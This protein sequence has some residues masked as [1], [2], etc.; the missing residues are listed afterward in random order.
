LF[1][2]D[3]AAQT[4]AHF[5]LDKESFKGGYYYSI[6]EL[7]G[8]LNCKTKYLLHL[9]GDAMADENGKWIEDTIIYMEKDR[10]I[11]VSATNGRS[12]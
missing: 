5:G 2:D 8:I 3:F 6:Q 4:L 7:T 12:K 9:T 10:S 11:C 1:V